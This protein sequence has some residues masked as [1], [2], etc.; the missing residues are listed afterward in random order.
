MAERPDYTRRVD[1]VFARAV[2]EQLSEQ[3]ELQALLSRVDEALVAVRAGMDQLADQVVETTT[4][5]ADSMATTRSAVLTALDELRTATAVEREDFAHEVSGRLHGVE[6][7]FERNLAELGVQLINSGPYHPQTLGKLERFHK[8]LKIWLAD[9]G[10]A[11]DLE[12][13][14][15][16]LDGFRHH[17]NKERP[18]QGIGNITPAE[19]YRRPVAEGDAPISTGVDERGEPVYPSHAHV[20]KVDCNGTLMFQGTPINV[21]RRWVGARARVIPVGGLIQ[22]YY[23]EELVRALAIDPSRK[24]Q[25]SRRE[26]SRQEAVR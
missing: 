9:E 17:Y 19:R 8:T 11:W 10:P 14:Q 16:L 26:A 12:H 5:V 20:R 22:I 24:Y 23:G 2:E 6:V 1:E 4:P 21:G 25:G 18:H 3:R 13:L 15:E 7:A